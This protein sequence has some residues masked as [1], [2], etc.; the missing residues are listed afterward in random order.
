MLTGQLR[1]RGGHVQ[2][3]VM[4]VTLYDRVADL[5]VPWDW[6]LQWESRGGISTVMWRP[7]R[8]SAYMYLCFLVQTSQR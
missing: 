1:E 3:A 4:P 7:C 6:I 5:N 2:G 8:M